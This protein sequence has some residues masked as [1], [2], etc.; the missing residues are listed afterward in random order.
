MIAYDELAKAVERY[1]AA[2]AAFDVADRELRA[3]MDRRSRGVLGK[4][5]EGQEGAALEAV[6]MVVARV[7]AQEYAVRVVDIFSSV[8]NARVVTPRHVAM[9][10]ARRYSRGTYEAVGAAF[11][12]NHGTVIH[13]ER[14]VDAR[15]DTQASYREKFHAVAVLCGVALGADARAAELART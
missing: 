9:V 8:R 13:A 12:R 1:R 2:E 3:V 11:R 5:L 6:V 10:L 7:V 14:S 4:Q 15:C